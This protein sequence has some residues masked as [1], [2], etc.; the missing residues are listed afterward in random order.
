M[1]LLVKADISVMYIRNWLNWHVVEYLGSGVI[2]LCM[3]SRSKIPYWCQLDLIL[4]CWVD[5][6]K[7]DYLVCC[8]FIRMVGL[9]F[10][11]RSHHCLVFWLMLTWWL[12]II[13]R[14]WCV[15]E[16]WL[17]KVL[18]LTWSHKSS[19]LMYFCQ[20]FL[21]SVLALVHVIDSC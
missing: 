3:F 14:Y 11:W 10:S 1:L 18:S 20:T 16:I 13:L 4:N 7:S 21:S 2:S 9:W 5:H 15:I 6:L 12:V 17:L 8:F 19:W